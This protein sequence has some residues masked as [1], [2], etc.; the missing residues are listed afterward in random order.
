MAH[1]EYKQDGYIFVTFTSS[2]TWEVPKGVKTVDICVV[3]GGHNGGGHSF[4]EY[5]VGYGGYHASGGF[6]GSGGKVV[7]QLNYSVDGKLG[8]SVVVG[9]RDSNSQFDSVVA[10]GNNDNYDF[11]PSARGEVDFNNG[12]LNPYIIHAQIGH[13][14]TKCSFN[15]VYYGGGGGNGGVKFFHAGSSGSPNPAYAN[16][17]A[18]MHGAGTPNGSYPQANSGGGGG[19]TYNECKYDYGWFLLS[20]SPQNGASGTVI[21]RYIEPKT[22]N[23]LFF[24]NNF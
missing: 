9:S 16:T 10:S 24:A 2:E 19:G 7:E 23:S 20:G 13:A 21:V 4:Y 5:S 6:G 17:G 18:G 3:S 14:G 15:N 1:S 11:N 8:I 12:G 22:V